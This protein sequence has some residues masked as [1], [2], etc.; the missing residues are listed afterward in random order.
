MHFHLKRLISFNKAIHTSLTDYGW[1]V[2]FQMQLG[3]QICIFS[4]DIQTWTSFHRIQVM[5]PYNQGGRITFV[6]CRQQCSKC[7]TLFGRA[8]VLGSFPV[9]SWTAYIAYPDTVTIMFFAMGADHLRRSCGFYRSVCGNHIMIATAPIVERT[10]ITVDVPTTQLAALLVGG[11]VNY[12]KSN[13]AHRLKG[14]RLLRRRRHR[15]ITVQ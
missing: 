14:Y 2:R 13:I 7:D 3:L 12:D 15:S 10:V 4:S 6:Q 11:A 9:G 5:M 1:P 8:G